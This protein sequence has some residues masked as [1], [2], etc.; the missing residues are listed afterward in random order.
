MSRRRG[1]AVRFPTDLRLPTPPGPVPTLGPVV[2]TLVFDG[3]PRH[4]DLSDVACPRLVR[5]L[6]RE[7]ADIGGQNGTVR[8]WS[9][10]AQMARHLRAFLGFVAAAEPEQAAELGLDDL[11]PELLDA[12]EAKLAADYGPDSGEPHAALRTVV[13]LLRLADQTRPDALSTPMHARVGFATRHAFQ[14]RAQPLDAYP[15]P[16][17]E[18]I[19]AAALADV[20]AIRDRIGAG[21]RLAAEGAD[22]Q[23]AGWGRLENVLWHIARH[24][25]LTSEHRRIRPVRSGPGGAGGFNAH[26]F[27]T[28]ADL[29]PFIVL[30]ICQTGLEPECAKGLRAGCL[31]N[32][33]RGFISIALCQEARPQR[34]AQDHPGLRRGRPA[35][36]RRPDPPG[37]PVDRAGPPAD[38][39]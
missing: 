10:F 8:E 37:H 14:P 5:P 9:G 35:L 18:A 28:S 33:A 29:V 32:P 39:R 15:L 17:F 25:P 4:I 24:G 38:R 20:R 26:L 13:R 23:V 19:Q 2:F 21:E 12:W 16:V 22:P 7:L 31:V 30:V 36:P 27:L 34:L 6:A 3:R 11:E 1:R